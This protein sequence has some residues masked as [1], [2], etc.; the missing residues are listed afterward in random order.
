MGFGLLGVAAV[1][2]AATN[3]DNLVVTTAQYAA[4]PVD[5]VRR[6]TAGQLCGFA[7]VLGVSAGGAAA[8]FEIPTRWIG[9][10]GLVPL[11]LGLRGLVALVRSPD[12]PWGS[13]WP[14]A[15]GFTTAALVTI[16]LSADNLAVYIPLFREHTV[17]AGAVVAACF[18]VFD[19]ALCAGARLAGRHRRTVGFLQRVGSWLSPLVY[20]VIGVVVLIGAGTIR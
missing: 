5:R 4:A 10:L 11:V 12:T 3:V 18:T 19:V 2:F 6:I 20:C 17:A 1:S 8:L 14:V 13:R 15:G 7:V 16:G 9:L